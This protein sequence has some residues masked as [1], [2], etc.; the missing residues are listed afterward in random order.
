MSSKEQQI[1]EFDGFRIEVA[2]RRLLQAGSAVALTPKV[3]DTLLYLVQ[4]S[5]EVLSKEDLMEAIWPERVVEENNLSQNISTLRRVLGQGQ[6]DSRYIVTAPGQGYRFVA[7]VAGIS[8]E[9]VQQAGPL[10]LA[11]LPFENIGAGPER[12][13]LADGLTEETIAALGQ[14]DPQHFSVIGRTSVMKYKGTTKTLAEI[15]EELGAAYL[16]E[17]SLRAEAERFRIT[18]KLIRASDQVQVWSTSHDSEPSSMLVF[19]Q[20]LSST[21]A[22]Q[23]RLRLSPERVNALA[24]RQTRNAEAYD[25][26]LRG[27]H[28]WH[29]LS[30][31]T[32]KRA[33]DYFSKATQLDTDYALAWS[34]IADTL[35]ST[36]I[37]GDAPA[38]AVWP[39]AQEAAAHA[40]RS[41]PD[42][43]EA[44]T[45]L[46]FVNFWLDW[47]WSAAE[48]AFR[49]AM[50][51]DPNYPLPHR[52]LGIM[53]AH[54]GRYQ[55]ARPAMR[56]ARELEPLVAVYQALSSQ[57]AFMGRDFEV[58]KQFARQAIVIDPEFWVGHLQLGQTCE[59]LR[60]HDLGLEALQA[61]VRLSNG[62]SKAISLR[63][64]L[65]AKVG[66][67]AEAEEM[68]KTLEGVSRERFVP[69]YALALIHAGLGRKELAFEWLERALDARDVHLTFLP[70]DAKWDAF[71]DDVR[72]AALLKRC[73]F[74]KTAEA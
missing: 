26:Y 43:A 7:E 15:G 33:I 35:A 56:R 57:V 28:L 23:I 12:D 69:P 54:M 55:E 18:S 30:P 32:T 21:I 53:Y 73:E 11:V 16:I 50:A 19:Q 44:Q 4:H 25:L 58:A 68:L 72:F 59:Q 41:E 62:N 66:K 5:G 60:E 20:E 47:D 52:M 14:I 70:V 37:N 24:R 61:A 65:F 38:L 2:K 39:R 64:Y 46:C 9:P 1:Y 3:F 27:R 31:P 17:S 40:V 34:G 48:A 10:I 49:K 6:G 63:G 42:L 45:S 22:E 36:P 29:Q 74:M 71:R 67:I 51:L 8:A 13:Y